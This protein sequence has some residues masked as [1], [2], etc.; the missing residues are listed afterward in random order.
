MNYRY[1]EPSVY[2][3]PG[4]QKHRGVVRVA[5]VICADGQTRYAPEITGPHAFEDEQKT[6]GKGMDRTL[7]SLETARDRIEYWAKQ[8][9]F[10]LEKID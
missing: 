10:R 4:E 8:N 2:D 9:N 7:T 5:P 6:D 3:A 1:Y